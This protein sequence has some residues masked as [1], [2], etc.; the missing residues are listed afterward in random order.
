MFNALT[1]AITS[2]AAV[3]CAPRQFFGLPSPYEYFTATY[4]SK[5]GVCELNVDLIKAGGGLNTSAISLLMLAIL[6]IIL[7]LA[8]LVT[9]GYIIYAGVQYVTAQGEPD[10]AKRALNTI[11]NASIGL[12]ITIIS[13]A[14]V[15]F[16]GHRLGANVAT[17]EGLPKV[18]ADKGSLAVLLNIV[19]GVLAAA[20]LLVLVIAGLRYVMSGGDPNTMTKT[21]NTIIYSA[22][23]LVVAMS[24]FAMVAFLLS[25]L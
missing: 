14:T 5:V 4:N 16:I 11:I 9:V 18:A 8:A 13:A 24:G 6:D 23:G 2:F 19:F 22:I 3:N 1:N 10:K 12:G 20:S 7:R 21:K 17:T 25:N 15:S